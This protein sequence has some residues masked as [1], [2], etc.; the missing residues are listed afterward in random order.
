MSPRRI[1]LGSA[2]TLGI[3][4]GACTS[5]LTLNDTSAL[6]QY[7]AK[8]EDFLD[9]SEIDSS[10]FYV[11]KCLQIDRNYAPAS[12]LLG[13]IYLYKDGIYNRRLS[14]FAL[15]E[16]VR[17]D[18]ENPEY[19]Y[20]LGQ[21]LEKQGFYLNAL[22]EYRRAAEL[23][24]T[25][26]RS[27]ER[28]AEINKRLGLR[29]DEPKYF[30]RALEASARAASIS[31]DPSQYYQQGVALYQLGSFD[32]SAQALT[33][34]IEGS[35]DRPIL[36]QCLLLLGAE[37]AITGKYDS[38]NVVFTKARGYLSPI[39]QAEMDDV[40]Y[41]MP[42]SENARLKNES[43]FQQ[44]RTIS[45]FWG[46][47]DPDPTTSVNERKLV[48][49]ARF[50]H[51]QITFSIPEK[52]IDGWKTKHGEMYIRYGAPTEQAFSLGERDIDPPRWIWRYDQF[53]KPVIFVFEDT[54]LNGDFDFPYPGK[55]WTADDFANDPARIASMLSYAEPQA[56]AFGAGSGPLKYYYLPRQFKGNG[57]KTD[58]EV[59]I[60][61]LHTELKFQRSGDYALA[62]ID[63]RQVLKYQDWAL[64]DSA[65]AK[66]TYKIRAVLTDNPD[67]SISDRLLISGY[68]DSLIFAIAVRDSASNHVGISTR[69]FRLRDFYTGQVEISDIVLA[70]KIDQPPGQPSFRRSE[71]GIYSNLDNHY[72]SGEPIWLYFEIYNLQKGPDGKTS[73]TIRQAVAE[74]RGP[75]VLASIKDAINGGELKE[76]ITSYTGG[77]V[78]S[79]ENRILMVDVSQFAP[80]NYS[81]SVEINDLISGKSAKSSEDI[82]IYK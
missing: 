18:K 8:A 43:Y 27:F 54:F 16:A 70:R 66:R 68:P 51:A 71:L 56:F 80:G 44:E 45:A 12:H 57:G 46:Q 14:A 60:A 62:A 2:I 41:L 48:H 47:L 25:D 59:F 42:P 67:L 52:N 63:W 53:P 26:Y 28:I 24:S 38:A 82:V 40:H 78:N 61:I 6:K 55:G 7:Y 35:N 33:K 34:G 76:V 36:S 5:P 65:G 64:A 39:A 73:Y 21:T 20:S 3:L 13:R 74:R 31:G 4:S 75:G 79:D 30:K 23:D 15:R 9:K 29:Y 37:L 11:N 10:L 69:E 77:S 22:D 19:H 50:V 32:S 1:L 81:L 49:Y 17:S 72:F 58:L